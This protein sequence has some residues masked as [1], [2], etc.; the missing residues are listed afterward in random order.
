MFCPGRR[1]CGVMKSSAI[2]SR[3]SVIIVFRDIIYVIIV[4][5]S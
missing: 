1:S 4:L 2:P 5:Y 3:L